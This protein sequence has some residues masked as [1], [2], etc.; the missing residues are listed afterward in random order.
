M[1]KIHKHFSFCC[2]QKS[3]QSDFLIPF[4]SAVAGDTQQTVQ[5][6]TSRLP[7]THAAVTIIQTQFLL[8]PAAENLTRLLV[9][10][11]HISNS[12]RHLTFAEVWR[13]QLAATSPD[14][15]NQWLQSEW[16]PS[17]CS[18]TSLRALTQSLS[19]PPVEALCERNTP[20]CFLFLYLCYS[21]ILIMRQTYE[22]ELLSLVVSAAWLQVFTVSFT[23]LLSTL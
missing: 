5:R 18:R 23:P 11:P 7:L 16:R 3:S 14:S 10:V 1:T 21:T 13:S 22:V 8:L 17:V 12:F 15:R 2:I 4:V 6:A 9:Y 19:A 20:G